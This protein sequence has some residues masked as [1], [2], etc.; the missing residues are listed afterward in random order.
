MSSDV[1]LLVRLATAAKTQTVAVT[2]DLLVPPL[3]CPLCP[4][5]ARASVPQ[6]TLVC[7]L[8][9]RVQTDRGINSFAPGFWRSAEGF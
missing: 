2:P 3:L 4:H 9:G 8:E 5:F 1:S 7:L 6:Q